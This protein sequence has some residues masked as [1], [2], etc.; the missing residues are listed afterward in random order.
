MNVPRTVKLA[1]AASLALH[2]IGADGY[3]QS[4]EIRE[5]QV[6]S[7]KLPDTIHTV[8]LGDAAVVDARMA[9]DDTVLVIGLGTGHTNMIVYDEEGI[10]IL[11]VPITVL[12]SIDRQ[13]ITVIG[14]TNRRT[15]ECEPFRCREIRS[16]DQVIHTEVN[17]EETTSQTIRDYP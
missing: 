8:A 13:A 7:L 3:A 9:F 10:E 1:I 4:L 12:S 16:P 14:G 5:G 11:A 2:L 17:G 6:T 15:I